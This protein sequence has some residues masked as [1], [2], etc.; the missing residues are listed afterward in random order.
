MKF[1]IGETTTPD[2]P[3]GNKKEFAAE[4]EADTQVIASN[5]GE[6][7]VHNITQAAAVSAALDLSKPQVPGQPP[8][9]P[10]RTI[11]GSDSDDDP[12]I[13]DSTD[14]PETDDNK[15]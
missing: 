2:N 13:D 12:N 6:S 15:F 1:T 11:P 4:I 5:V 14:A 8:E 9:S 7:R 3:N 10:G